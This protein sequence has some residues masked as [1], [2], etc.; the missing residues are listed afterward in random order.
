VIYLLLFVATLAEADAALLTAAF[1][2][3]R[4]R[5]NLGAVMAVCI[6]ATLAANQFWF[7]LGRIKGRAFLE[8]RMRTDRRLQRIHGWL[9]RR[10]TLVIPASRFLYGFRVAIP[11]AYGAAG[12][13]PLFFA[14]LEVCSALAW[15]IAVG[16]GGYALGDTLDVVLADLERDE[17][18]IAAALLVAGAVLALRRR[19]RLRTALAAL[20]RPVDA[21]AAFAAWMFVAARRAGGML[22]T[23]PHGRL[24]ALA[25]ALG[26]LNVLSAVVGTRVLHLEWLVARLPFEITH[27]SRALMLLAGV[28]LVYLGRGLARRKQSAWT[29]ALGLAV[30]SSLLYLAHHASVLRAAFSAVFALDLWRQRHRFRARTDPL[31]L[32]HA[33]LA[34]PLLALAV[35]VYGLAGLREFGRPPAGMVDAMR[36]VWLTA[37]F[38]VDLALPGTPAAAFVWSLRLLFVLSAGYVLSASLAP[39]AWLEI[40]SRADAA[41]VA[42][43]AWQ[44]GMDSM[45]CF[46]RHDDKRHFS[47]DGRAFVGFRVRNRVAVVAGDPV[48]EADAIA[49]LIAAFI[50][51]CRAHDWVPAFYETSDRY[52]DVYRGGGLRFFKIGEEAVLPLPRW[53]LS[54]GAVAKVRQFVNKVRREAPDLE[55]VEYR[56]DHPAGDI[57]DQLEDISRAWLAMKKGGEM[58]FNLGIF[59]VEDLADTRTLIAR[60]G[61]GTVEAFVTWLPYRAGR[62]VV[63]DA[64]RHRPGAQPGVMDLLIAESARRFREEGLEAA[65]LAMAPLANADGQAPAS[66]YDRG[67]KLIFEHV[68]RVYGYRTLFQY[69]KKFGPAW[70]P[71]Y[72]VFPRPDQLPRIAFALVTVHYSRR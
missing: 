33:L 50:D 53:S 32:R 55:V 48:G 42:A 19:A 23:H 21:G 58:G 65:S 67:V 38:Q 6:A 52:L 43:L 44:H 12:T 35:T 26:A 4:G 64:M 8:R 34:T 62:A 41:R 54:G 31:R 36:V 70:E 39:V 66:P 30:L 11:V 2:A 17:L 69:K 15:G 57:D 60:R 16:F 13:A 3:H 27:G 49:P 24:A 56:R 5:L 25:V 47:I 9:E 72:L 28:G 71:R 51:L 37:G 22:I 68:S 7:W 40:P 45:S 63:L 1:L 10:G 61:D 18:A 14:L 20:R 29:M 46:A 59:S